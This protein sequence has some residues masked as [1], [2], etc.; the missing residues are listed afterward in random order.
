[1]SK[2]YLP[3]DWEAMED[4]LDTIKSMLDKAGIPEYESGCP[5]TLPERVAEAL[6]RL[7]AR[8]HNPK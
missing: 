5:L 7:K 4:E 2:V 3:D 1:M 6:C 8:G